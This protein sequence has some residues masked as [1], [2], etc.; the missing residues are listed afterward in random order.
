MPWREEGDEGAVENVPSD[1]SGTEAVYD[2]SPSKLKACE[3]CAHQDEPSAS[4]QKTHVTWRSCPLCRTDASRSDPVN[5]R[6]WH[7]RTRTKAI[8][9]NSTP[10]RGLSFAYK[11]P[12]QQ[13]P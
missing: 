11:A 8:V 2:K 1:C 7:K 5:W 4:S 13:N 12:N 6:H 3:H 10:S 9:H